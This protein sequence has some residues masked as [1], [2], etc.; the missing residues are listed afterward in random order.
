MLLSAVGQCFGF[1]LMLMEKALL[2][3][4]FWKKSTGMFLYSEAGVCVSEVRGLDSRQFC[5]APLDLT[6]LV[7]RS[8]VHTGW[9][10]PSV[11]LCSLQFLYLFLN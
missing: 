4:V 10:Q 5:D 9:E 2:Y 11:Y 6:L 7:V 8:C 1:W 3:E